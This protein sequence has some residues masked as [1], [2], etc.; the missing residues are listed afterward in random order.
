MPTEIQQIDNAQLDAKLTEILASGPLY[1]EYRYKGATGH[2]LPNEITL[3]CPQCLRETQFRYSGGRNQTDRGQYF[4][5]RYVCS[6]C[7]REPVYYSYNWQQSTENIAGQQV[8]VF[9]FSKYGQSP[10]LEERLTKDLERALEATD[11]LGFYKTAL[12]FRNFGKGIGAMAYMRRV[13]EG[14]MGEM[15]E[16]LND[17]VRAKG[18]EPMSAEEVSSLKFSQKV[19][20][21][22]DLFPAVI[23]PQHYPNP[24]EQLYRLTSDGLHNLSEDE[25]IILFDQCRHVFEY[26]FSELRPHLKTRKKFLDDLQTLPRLGTSAQ[27]KAAVPVN[28][29][30]QKAGEPGA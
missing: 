30:A 18:L 22:K 7:N 1:T 26:V 12:R 2:Q 8:P 19:A 3:Y 23:K 21:A 14:H 25:S 9:S 17:E 20:R 13:I 27:E 4:Q 10:P 15:L 16:I 11:D 6:N 28:A 5:R 24:F 29:E